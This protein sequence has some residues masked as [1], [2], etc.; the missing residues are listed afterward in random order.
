MN[1][2][3]PTPAPEAVVVE[4]LPADTKAPVPA[5]SFPF[6]PSDFAPSKNDQPWYQKSNKS[7]HNKLPGAAPHG[8]RKSMG[9][10]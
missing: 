2:S 7:G 10:R 3:T 9:K 1:S 6:K 4:D 5:F 8:T